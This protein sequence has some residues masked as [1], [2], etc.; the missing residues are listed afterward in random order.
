MNVQRCPEC[1]QR[2]KTNYCDICMRKVPFGGVKLANRRDPWDSSDG[3]S[4]HRLEK[5]HECVSFGEKKPVKTTFTK[6]QPKTAASNKKGASV[7]AIILAV[8]SLLPALFGLIEESVGS[9]PVP[10]PEYN[11]YEGFVLAG[12]PGAEDVP[13]VIAGEIYNADGI[14]ITADYA[15]LSYG[16]YTIFMTVCNDTDRDI[17]VSIDNVSVN[18]YML[19]YGMYQDVAAG[20]SVQTYLTLYSHELEKTPIVKVSDVTFSLDIYEETSSQQIAGG[21]LVAVKTEY[22]GSTE[23]DVDISGMELYNDGSL[24]VLLSGV[25]LSDSGDCQLDLYMEN[26]S[27]SPV[28]IYS[29]AVWVNGEEVSGYIGKTLLPDTR[30]MDSGY[31]YELDERVDL[32]IGELSQI[33]E[34][35]IEL[36]VE[37]MDGWDVVESYSE[38]ITFEPSAIY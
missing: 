12:D 38:K 31:L 10:E 17:G 20:E 23:P 6:P 8:L 25:S 13:N 24:C 5:G 35:T 7:V 26:L 28:N 3:S 32:D 33:R 1:G 15:G 18:T 19:S 29:G 4:A 36:Y 9:E 34:I 11:I 30:A 27:G 22:D 16:E 2:L 21:E 14:Q 37:Y